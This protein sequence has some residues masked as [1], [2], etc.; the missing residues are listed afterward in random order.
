MLAT[1]DLVPKALQPHRKL[2]AIDAGR[3]VL[4]LKQAA[5]LQGARL[6]VVPFGHI[7]D[8]SMR[9]KLRCSIA[10]Y[11]TSGVML[12]GSGN[13]LARCLRRM[14]VPDPRLCIPLQFMQC[15]ANTF[16]VLLAHAIISTHKSRK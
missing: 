12:E 5:L 9:M 2:G 1:L 6:S 16:A 4:R 14:D 8:D 11:G 13:E 7:E 10:V 15:H 3:I